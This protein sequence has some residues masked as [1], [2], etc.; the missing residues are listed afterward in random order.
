MSGLEELLV[1]NG[2][3][4]LTFAIFIG[5]RIIQ[6]VKDRETR[7]QK[8]DDK[9]I[10]SYLEWL[11]EQ[12][13]ALLLNTIETTYLSLGEYYKIFYFCLIPISMT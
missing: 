5:E 2:G 10:V 3:T 1:T 9:I 7:K 11:R 6:A 13:H 8:I 12:D 4:L